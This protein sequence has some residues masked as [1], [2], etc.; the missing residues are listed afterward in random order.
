M[1]YYTGRK[2]K[3]KYGQIYLTADNYQ[4][5][6]TAKSIESLTTHSHGDWEG[7]LDAT[8]TPRQDPENPDL[9]EYPPGD[10]TDTAKRDAMHGV[11]P[12]Q[13]FGGIRRGS[14]TME[15]FYAG[16]LLMPRAGNLAK[17]QLFHLNGSQ[18]H[19]FITGTILVSEINFVQTVRGVFR[20][21]L[22]GDFHGDFDVAAF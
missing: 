4:Y 17:V 20:W 1:S 6:S 5:G 12:H 3:V 13:I 15:G 2:A 22:K 7:D 18:A 11:T 21:F 8:Y 19:G 16:P 14:V 10:E 9:G